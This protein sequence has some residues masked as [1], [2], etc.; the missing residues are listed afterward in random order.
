[1][2]AESSDVGDP[3]RRLRAPVETPDDERCRCPDRPPVKLMQ[4]LGANP[5]HCMRCHGEVAPESLPLPIELADPLADW[6]SVH[7]ALDRLWLDSGAYEA[8]A[9]SELASLESAVNRAGLALRARIDAVRR[10]YYWLVDALPESP[11]ASP[12]RCPSCDG[13]MMPWADGRIAQLVCESCSL[14]AR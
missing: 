6:S 12:R 13:Q 7:D 8:W 4:A 10:C 9:A 14:V 2:G 11:L 3:Y 1:M 5:L